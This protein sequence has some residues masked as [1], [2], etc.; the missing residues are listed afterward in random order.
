MVSAWEAVVENL[1]P[2][3]ADLWTTPGKYHRALNEKWNTLKAA[4]HIDWEM[5]LKGD[6]L[7][8]LDL[9]A[10]TGWLSIMLSTRQNIERIY[11][12]DASRNNLRQMLPELSKL[13][14]GNLDKIIRVLGLFTP[15]LIEDAY[16]D[17]AVAS[18]ALHHAPDL[19][20]CLAEV[21][22]VLKPG[23]FL[24]ILNEQ[25]ITSSRYAAVT[26]VRCGR[27]IKAVILKRWQRVAKP[28]SENNIVTDPILG[29]KAYCSWQWRAAIEGA[30]FSLQILTTPYY[31]YQNMDGQQRI[32]LTHFVAE[33]QAAR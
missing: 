11:A 7:K 1:P 24:I 12:L 2:H 19:A 9:G 26:A 31:P 10:G 18:A 14:E 16:F 30:G 8:V 25:P 17:L 13:M 15:I 22:R 32:K 4:K 3:E 29:D 23:G 21:Y 6:S 20:E 28:V 5:Y 33:K 27:I